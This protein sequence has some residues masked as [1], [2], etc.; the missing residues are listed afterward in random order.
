[1][2]I[3]MIFALCIIAML[4]AIGIVYAAVLTAQYRLPQTAIA[5]VGA[6]ATFVINGQ[7]WAN[8]TSIDWGQLKMGD[9]TMTILVKNVGSV[10]IASVTINSVNLPSSWTETIV[11]GVPSGDGIP[12]TIILHADATVIGPQTWVSTITISSPP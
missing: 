10:A 7:D 9:N 2:K 5:P 3:K 8:N 11:M 1:M 6:A 12:G 4:F